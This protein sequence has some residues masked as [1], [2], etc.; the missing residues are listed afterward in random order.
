M[1]QQ[2]YGGM[3]ARP[4]GPQPNPVTGSTPRWPGLAAAGLILM[5]SAGPAG[6]AEAEAA[7]RDGVSASQ[8]AEQKTGKKKRMPK[9]R[10][11]RL[12]P[13][14][15]VNKVFRGA[16]PP[17][18]RTLHMRTT[19]SDGS[20][21]E[22][23]R[24]TLLESS[25]IV[26]AVTETGESEF[27]N[28]DGTTWHQELKS[29]SRYVLGG[30]LFVE[31]EWSGI[32]EEQDG[33]RE[34]V[35]EGAETRDFSRITGHLFPLAVGNRLSLAYRSRIKTAREFSESEVA[36]R[37]VRMAA[38]RDIHP[39]LTGRIFVIQ[40]EYKETQATETHVARE[41]IYYAPEIG[42]PVLQKRRDEL[43]GTDV[44]SRL[45]EFSKSRNK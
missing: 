15:A 4:L 29:D 3:E 18:F 36:F 42:W 20:H 17:K 16:P 1:P 11:A 43:F 9:V 26:I 22:D 28:L 41:E 44:E 23:V 21:R 12:A 45:V 40:A 27:R 6:A 7:A 10:Q 37:V 33:V 24:Y 8:I 13:V 31:G 38:A 14:F 30:L 35:K 34:V 5:C 19:A 25:G 2:E 39:R 32:R